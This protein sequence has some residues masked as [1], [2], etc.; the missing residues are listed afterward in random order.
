MHLDLDVLEGLIGDNPRARQRILVKFEQLIK[1][2][3]Q[4]VIGAVRER[5]FDTVRSACH[6]LKSS[7]RSVGAIELGRLSEQLEAVGAG[8]A[9]GPIEPLLDRFLEECEAV[10][11]ELTE[12]ADAASQP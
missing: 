9:P 5:E 12:K 2:T 3:R 8:R 6:S 7:S 1:D 4:T 11:Q 10:E